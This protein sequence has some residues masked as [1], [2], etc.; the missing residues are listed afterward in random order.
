MIYIHS[1]IFAECASHVQ[2]EKCISFNY[3]NLILCVVK[4]S[5]CILNY[6]FCQHTLHIEQASARKIGIDG[7][8]LYVYK[9]CYAEGFVK[10]RAKLP[11][12]R[13]LT[14]LRCYLVLADPTL[15][16]FQRKPNNEIWL[17][18]QLLHWFIYGAYFGIPIN[19]AHRTQTP[20]QPR[21][22]LEANENQMK[23][24]RDV[25][26]AFHSIRSNKWPKTL[27]GQRFTNTTSSKLT[28]ICMELND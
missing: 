15:D 11:L 10:K 26:L 23:N 1:A 19:F 25:C 8:F 20:K 24:T 4:P 6:L 13:R 27:Y 22:S 5:L 28:A 21:S 9:F 16:K 14:E 3:C 2:L 12:F 17:V 18:E 7:R